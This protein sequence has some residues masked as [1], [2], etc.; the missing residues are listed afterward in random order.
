MRILYF[1]ILS[2]MFLL[3]PQVVNS[4]NHWNIHLVQ[5][6]FDCFTNQACYQVE[7]ANLSGTAWTLGDQNYR[8]FFDGDW[9]TIN[10]VTSLLP[11]NFYGTATIDQNFTISGQGQ[12]PLSPLDDI[13]W[14][15]IES[16]PNW[17]SFPV[18]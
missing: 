7:L 11:A 12:E 14:K 5:S 18:R 13:D 1:T 17:F 16:S 9:M 10:A 6:S 2:S 15:K 8:F 4:Q 3:I